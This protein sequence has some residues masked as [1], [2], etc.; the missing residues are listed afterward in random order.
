[1]VIT[2]RALHVA[3]AAAAVAD[4]DA[5]AAP[6]LVCVL[7]KTAKAASKQVLT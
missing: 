6:V 7:E 1:L 3:A 2:G 5:A 4:A